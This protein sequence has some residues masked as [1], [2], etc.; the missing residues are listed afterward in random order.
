MTIQRIHESSKLVVTCDSDLRPKRR[1]Y[2]FFAAFFFAFIGAAGAAGV[3]IVI[4]SAI[5]F[6]SPV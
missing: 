4:M 1:R 5:I 6:R 2:F 3:A